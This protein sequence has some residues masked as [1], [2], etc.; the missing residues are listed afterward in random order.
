MNW[1]PQFWLNR[2][3]PPPHRRL[4][5]RKKESWDRNYS[6][7]SHVVEYAVAALSSQC[8]RYI[9]SIN[10]NSK[11]ANYCNSNAFRHP[12]GWFVY[13]SLWFTEKGPKTDMEWSVEYLRWRKNALNLEEGSRQGMLGAMSPRPGPGRI[14]LISIMRTGE[15]RPSPVQYGVCRIK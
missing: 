10:T 8:I 3:I 12:E 5:R 4:Y 11:S 9:C 7:C 14:W 1:K 6:A 2:V 15:G 13:A